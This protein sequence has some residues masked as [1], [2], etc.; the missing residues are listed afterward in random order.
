MEKGWLAHKLA[1][2]AF[3]GA[4]VGNGAN[5][6]EV[7][8]TPVPLASIQPVCSVLLDGRKMPQAAHVI[9]PYTDKVH[10]SAQELRKSGKDVKG[11]GLDEFNA[12][13][14]E[15]VVRIHAASKDNTK[16]RKPLSCEVAGRTYPVIIPETIEKRLFSPK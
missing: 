4:G 5:A 7:E 15:F 6:A 9:D 16:D 1:T 13:A 11:P 12:S 2:V 14:G 3:V 10:F 8:P